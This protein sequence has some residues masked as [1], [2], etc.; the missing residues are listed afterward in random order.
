[1]KVAERNIFVAKKAIEQGEE[2]FRMN[3]ERYRQQ[4][5]TITDVLDAQTLLTK[6]QTDYYNA[7]RNFNVAKAALRRAMGLPVLGP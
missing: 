6:A 5:G 3:Q 2:N 4:V 7:L 1:M